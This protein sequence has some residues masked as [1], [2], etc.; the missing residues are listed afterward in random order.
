MY[1]FWGGEGCSNLPLGTLGISDSYKESILILL[2]DFKQL[3]LGF[4]KTGKCAKEK[5]LFIVMYC[6]KCP[7]LCSS[8]HTPRVLS[9]STVTNNLLHEPRN[10]TG[11]L[12]PYKRSEWKGKMSYQNWKIFS[13]Y[14]CFPSLFPRLIGGSGGGGTAMCIWKNKKL[15]SWF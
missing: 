6:R 8:G 9:P 11:S 3:L 12:G 13:K 2:S 1:F 7:R 10:A 4:K 15:P 5:I 14:T